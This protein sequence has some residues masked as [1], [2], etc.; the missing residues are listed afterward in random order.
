MY[1]QILLRR[2]WS[3]EVWGMEDGGVGWW[4]ETHR[5]LKRFWSDGGNP[6]SSQGI[7]I[8]VFGSHNFAHNSDIKYSRIHV[9]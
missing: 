5:H 9:F 1:S 7:L 4:L 6:H 8:S 2:T 3:V